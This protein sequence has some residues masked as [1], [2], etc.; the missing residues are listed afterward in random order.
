MKIVTSDKNNWSVLSRIF[1]KSFIFINVIFCILSL[2][3]WPPFHVFLVLSSAAIMGLN[4]SLLG[5]ICSVC[6]KQ[7]ESSPLFVGLAFLLKITL[8]IALLSSV[9]LL[10]SSYVP[11]FTLGCLGV[12]LSLLFVSLYYIGLLRNRK[13]L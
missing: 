13:L 11:P 10:P 5:F 9:F 6:T 8:W 2:F 7:K 3:L 12:V 1:W 4:F